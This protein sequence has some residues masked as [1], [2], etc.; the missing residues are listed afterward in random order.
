[1]VHF[2]CYCWCG[3]TWPFWYRNPLAFAG[4]SDCKESSVIGELPQME[5]A[6][7]LPPG[8]QALLQR[9]GSRLRL[10]QSI[11]K[12]RGYAKNSLRRITEGIIP[13]FIFCSSLVLKCCWMFLAV[14]PNE[15]AI[16]LSSFW[17]FLSFD[18]CLLTSWLFWTS[19]AACP[20]AIARVHMGPWSGSKQW[21]VKIPRVWEWMDI[22][23]SPRS[24]SVWAFWPMTWSKI[25][26]S[27]FLKPCTS[28]CNMALFWFI[29]DIVWP[30][31][32]PKVFWSTKVFWCLLSSDFQHP[33]LF[34]LCF[35]DR[36]GCSTEAAR[37]HH[38]TQ[39]GDPLPMWAWRHWGLCSSAW[40]SSLQA[41]VFAPPSI[42]CFCPGT[43]RWRAPWDEREAYLCAP[44]PF[45]T[46]SQLAITRCNWGVAISVFHVVAHGWLMFACG[47]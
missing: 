3:Q 8:K 19:P 27:T 4:F 40:A 36:L 12:N 43:A 45:M 38:W 28:D 10:W 42:C 24:R 46:V 33:A 37:Q 32:C 47:V 7:T 20:P 1:M 11:W 6:S 30:L 25:N 17:V 29:Y 13:V 14:C 16:E 15:S 44:W 34:A 31:S 2:C 21:L 23:W 18:S 9:F 5:N 35:G 26:R 22:G 41:S 39:G